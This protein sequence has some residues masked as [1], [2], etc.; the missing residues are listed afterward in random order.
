MDWD[1]GHFW[2]NGYKAMLGVSALPGLLFDPPEYRQDGQLLPDAAS[3]PGVTSALDMGIGSMT[4][5]DIEIDLINA[6]AEST[7]APAR[8]SSRH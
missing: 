6:T 7:G 3:P 8:S 4:D 5:P 1:K 2:E